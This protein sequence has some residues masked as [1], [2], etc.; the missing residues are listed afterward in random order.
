MKKQEPRLLAMWCTLEHEFQVRRRLSWMSEMARPKILWPPRFWKYNIDYKSINSTV[1]YC[2][3]IHC[4][5]WML[6]LNSQLYWM[7]AWNI[8]Y[9]YTICLSIFNRLPNMIQYWQELVIVRYHIVPSLVLGL[10]LQSCWFLWTEQWW[11]VIKYIYSSA[12]FQ[13]KHKVLVLY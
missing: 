8:Q 6:P 10:S 1:L 3:I 7:Q 2:N 5:I 12:V 4:I 9:T 11:N 13:Y